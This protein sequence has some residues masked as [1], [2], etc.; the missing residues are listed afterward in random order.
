R[1]PQG[2]G[3]ACYGVQ[4]G[5]WALDRLHDVSR[6][7]IRLIS[8]ST[9]VAGDQP[10]LVWDG[11]AGGA[12]RRL[13]LQRQPSFSRRHPV[14]IGEGKFEPENLQLV[15]ESIGLVPLELG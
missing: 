11:P 15:G 10:C 1:L 9:S 8:G 4:R 6:A 13:C 2:A 7:A 3:G 5:Q 12:M 14:A